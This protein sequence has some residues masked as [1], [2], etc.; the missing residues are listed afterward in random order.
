MK[1]LFND[2]WSFAKFPPNTDYATAKARKLEFVPV[3]L[4]HD[5]LISDAHKF[6]EDA[7]GWYRKRLYWRKKPNTS[8]FL[9]FEGVYMDSEVYFNGQ[10]IA[11]WKYGYSTFDVEIGKYLVLGGNEIMVHVRYQNPNSRWYSGAGIYRNVYIIELPTAHIDPDGIY[12]RTERRGEGAVVYVSVELS[13]DVR[14]RYVS[15]KGRLEGSACIASIMRTVFGTPGT[16]LDFYIPNVK[17]WDIEHPY[18]YNLT[19]QIMEGEVILQ[20]E[21][22]SFG[23]RTVRVDPDEGFFLNGRHIK[24]QGVCLHHDLGALGAAVNKEAIRRQLVIMKRMGVNAIRT[25]HNMPSVELME[26]A[27]EMGILVMSEAFDCWE[28]PKTE[29]DYARFFKDWWKRDVRSWVRRDRNH[30]SLVFWSIGNEIYD[31]H[32][33][34]RGQE[35]TRM[36]MKEVHKYDPAG[37]G[38]V[39]FGSNYMP[40]ENA[41]KCADIV[42]VAGYNYSEKC[43]DEHHKKYRDWVIYGS[44]TAS[45][46]QSRG[47]Y[48]FPLRQ[49]VLADVD[50]QCSSL[51][52]STTSWGAKN[53]E[54][55]I[56]AERDHP[57]SMGQFLWSG[58]DYIGEPTPYHTKNSYF[59]QVDTAGLAKD[60]YYLYQAAWTDEPMVHVFPYWDFNEGQKVD[61][62]VCSNAPEVEL[63]VNGRS[64]GRVHLD[65]HHL[66]A[67]YEVAYERGEITAE[68]YDGE[69]RLLARESRHSFAEPVAF[70]FIC[71]DSYGEV[72]PMNWDEDRSVLYFRSEARQMLFLEIIAKDADGYPVENANNR[73]K[74]TV[75]GEAE[76]LGLDNGDS[77]DYESYQAD[78]RKLFSGRLLA[79]V[80]TSGDTGRVEITAELVEEEKPRVRK[81]ELVSCDAV[82]LDAEHPKTDV[83][84]RVLP[85]SAA[86][87]SIRY[88]VVERGGVESNLAKLSKPAEPTE[89][90]RA[91]GFTARLHLTAKGDGVFRLRAMADNGEPQVRVISELNFEASGLGAACIDPYHFV[92]GELYGDSIGDIGNGNEHG[93]STMREGMSAIGFLDVDF[94]ET[95]AEE[96]KLPIFELEGK[97]TPIGIWLGRP[98]EEGS[99]LVS[100]VIYD[101]PTV[102]NTYQ[103]ATFWLPEQLRGVCDLYF[104]LHK[105]IHLKGFSFRKYQKAFG[106]LSAN[107]CQRVYGD[108]LRRTKEGIM[109]IG[110][111]VTIEFDDMDFGNAGS[112]RITVC[113]RTKNEKNTIQ[114]RFVSGK[115]EL[116][117]ALEFAHSDDFSEQTFKFTRVYGK[118]TVIFMFMPGSQFDF[119]WFRFEH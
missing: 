59:G 80:Q 113:G 115:R 106:L 77:T 108:H 17:E 107:Q 98:H 85:E 57:Y 51:G 16:E 49:P 69:G 50:E 11:E 37:N 114:V 86:G 105:K 116:T 97:P 63:F 61:V 44:E 18:T 48:H 60:S 103:E 31:M 33:G 1:Q 12:I 117:A 35:I 34:E 40:W 83:L 90:E 42:K 22:R 96:L 91:Q 118:Q 39:T 38:L 93:V 23:V 28:T 3:E 8:L 100:T 10:K 15:I 73:V 9:R 94:G 78:C 32:A 119:K 89:E 95:G 13:R 64:L 54:S 88:A 68:A 87:Q 109:D 66:T 30:P 29:Y 7:D 53:P 46:V 84:V 41:Q 52:N 110:N 58:F 111:N 26:L 47:I 19:V 43:Y 24:L 101:K 72:F 67:D 65:S 70:S 5:W 75:R 14:N 99:R 56:I 71:T 4:P 2:G 74:V 20:E 27:D 25:S 81:I 112:R 76:L 45:T 62:R 102:W 79:I 55:C 104:E 82:H 92:A 36:L 21:Q 6:Y